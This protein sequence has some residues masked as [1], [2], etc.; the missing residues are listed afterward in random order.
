MN[1]INKIILG[2]MIFKNEEEEICLRK[3]VIINN[4]IMVW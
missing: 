1:R 2:E 3:N 4:Q